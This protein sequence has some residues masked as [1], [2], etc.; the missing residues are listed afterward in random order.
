MK[1][2]QDVEYLSRPQLKE[3][4]RQLRTHVREHRDQKADDRCWMDDEKL[5]ESTLPE[6]LPYDRRVGDRCKMLANCERFLKTHCEGG[7]WTSY[8]DLEAFIKSLADRGCGVH[9]NGNPDKT[10]FELRAMVLANPTSVTDE[11]LLAIE[12]G[13]D[14]CVACGA[15]LVLEEG[16]V[17][18]VRR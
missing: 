14:F 5:Y 17:A 8:A 9:H 15:R 3:V 10:C 18:K 13:A 16:I 4:I 1:L 11:R 12:H 7:H 2:D 6:K